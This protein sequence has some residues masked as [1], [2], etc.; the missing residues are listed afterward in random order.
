MVLKQYLIGLNLSHYLL[1]YVLFLSHP[2]HIPA[3]VHFV[4]SKNCFIYKPSYSDYAQTVTPDQFSAT[5]FCAEIEHTMSGH[6]QQ[7]LPISTE[8][9]DSKVLG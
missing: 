1:E 5:L 9:N 4:S 6:H 8:T 3:T 2:S 7:I